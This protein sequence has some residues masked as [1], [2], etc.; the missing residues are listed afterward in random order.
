MT[1]WGKYKNGVPEKIDSGSVRDIP[2]LLR[3]YALA[4]GRDW[5]L[6]AGRKSDDPTKGEYE[7]ST[8]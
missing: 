4:F 6:W 3:E 1:I 8:R 7:T 5:V 2:Y